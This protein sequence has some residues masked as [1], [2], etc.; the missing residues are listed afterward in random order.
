MI[1]PL[2]NTGGHGK[3]GAVRSSGS[4]QS[5][6]CHA[7]PSLH[8]SGYRQQLRQSTAASLV[9]VEASKRLG[10]HRTYVLNDFAF[11]LLSDERHYGRPRTRA[12]RTARFKSIVTT[13]KQPWITSHLLEP[14]PRLCKDHKRLLRGECG[15][16]S[17]QGGGSGSRAPSDE[18]FPTFPNKG[19]IER[20]RGSPAGQDGSP[21]A[22]PRLGAAT[23][24]T[25]SS[26]TTT[27]RASP[28]PTCF[29]NGL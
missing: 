21:A 14:L 9:R 13:P 4:R 26:E 15:T 10:E 22:P 17:V 18:P 5:A 7:L 6:L 29:A 19:G 2:P 24:G 27:A 3:R 25:G 11:P 23:A 8:A 1:C 12:S 16:P 20:G 28:V